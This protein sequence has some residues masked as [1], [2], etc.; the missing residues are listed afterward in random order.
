VRVKRDVADLV[1]D[2]QRD[3][4]E[5]GELVVEAAASLGVGEQRDPL[6]RGAEG[7]ALAGEAGADPKAMA[8]WVLPVPGGPSRTTFSRP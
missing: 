2:E 1:A 5:A 4:L 8:R 7:D 3:A 6:G